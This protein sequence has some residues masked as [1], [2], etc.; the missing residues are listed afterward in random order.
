LTLEDVLKESPCLVGM[1][2]PARRDDGVGSWIAGRLR[3]NG[4]PC[5]D[6]EDVL[7]NH[8]YDIART[9]NPSV[10]IMDAVAAGMEPGA[11]VFG[12]L[13]G[14][15]EP[16]P[17][18]THKL[19]LGLCGRILE[20]SGKRVYLLGIVPRDLDYGPGLT[21]EVRRAAESISDLII[22]TLKP[23]GEEVRHAG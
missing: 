5:F 11:V 16:A 1:G 7:E 4:V 14:A 12:P 9:G 23:G 6:V 13:R 20:E 8:V 2:N 22:G 19:A 3:E 21:V 17:V 15:G 10:V 18:S